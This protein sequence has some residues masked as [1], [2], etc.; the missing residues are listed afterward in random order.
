[1]CIFVHLLIQHLDE[2]LF[3][4][5]GVNA[6][7]ISPQNF[8]SC[9]VRNCTFR[10]VHARRFRSAC[11]LV[12]SDQNLHGAFWI[13]KDAKFHHA[14]SKD[15]DHTALIHG[16]TGVFIGPTSLKVHFFKL[17]LI[18]LWRM[19]KPIYQAH[20]K[21]LFIDTG[22]FELLQYCVFSLIYQFFCFSV[23]TVGLHQ[24]KWFR[25]F[26][27]K[28]NTL[29]KYI[30]NFTSKNWK[31]SDKKVWYFFIFLLKT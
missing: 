16:L 2:M 25:A 15:S 18:F 22:Y 21:Y 17:W 8:M 23:L 13:A 31:F 1:M 6:L 10:H 26:I 27:H 20:V 30:E 5:K 7:F 12:P 9:S 3:Q 11:M 4:P 29:F 28:E 24:M 14:N 19:R